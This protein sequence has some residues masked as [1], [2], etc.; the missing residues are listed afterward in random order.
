MSKRLPFPKFVNSSLKRLS[1]SVVGGLSRGKWWFSPGSRRIHNSRFA[2][3]SSGES[4]GDKLGPG[5]TFPPI[6][7]SCWW[8]SFPK[9]PRNFLRNI[10]TS[11]NCLQF[12]Q[13]FIKISLFVAFTKLGTF[14]MVMKARFLQH[15]WLIIQ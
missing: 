2:L 6:Q 12:Y 5:D 7:N 1:L 15:I 4:A 8:F 3:G 9:L 14:V 13:S 10:A 11:Q